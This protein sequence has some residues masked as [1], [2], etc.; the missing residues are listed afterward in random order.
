MKIVQF[1]LEDMPKRVIAQRVEEGRKKGGTLSPGQ[2]WDWRPRVKT[3]LGSDKMY[4]HLSSNLTIPRSSSPAA[5]VLTSAPTFLE[6][7]DSCCAAHPVF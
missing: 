5:Y 3:G 1:Y 6:P 7:P 2:G 4:F